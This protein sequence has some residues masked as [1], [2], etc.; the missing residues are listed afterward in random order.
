MKFRNNFVH[1]LPIED[2]TDDDY[3]RATQASEDDC[4][5]IYSKQCRFSILG[6]LVS[7]DRPIL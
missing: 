5:S 4:N 2:E 3:G 1:S 7:K 6:Y